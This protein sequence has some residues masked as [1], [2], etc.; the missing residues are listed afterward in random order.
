MMKTLN[1]IFTLIIMFCYTNTISQS[2]I[3]GIFE[4]QTDIGDVKIAGSSSYDPSTDEY[5]LGGSGSNIW[6]NQD[7]FH[8]LWKSIEG[9]F[10]LYAE[11]AFTGENNEPH[12]KGGWMIRQAL[13]NNA[14]YVDATVHG[15]GL[16]SLQFR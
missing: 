5:L 13:S 9:D 6:F 1:L 16:T 2:S 3:Y 8:Y 14:P 4:E 12:R 10:I 7:E 11:L 15:D